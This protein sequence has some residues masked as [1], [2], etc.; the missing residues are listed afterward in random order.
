M[1]EEKVRVADCPSPGCPDVP[2]SIA[3]EENS[4]GNLTGS[5]ELPQIRGGQGGGFGAAIARAA[6]VDT[7]ASKTR[8]ATERGV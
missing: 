3:R 1:L 8:A 2:G 4:K 7:T 5:L 6:H